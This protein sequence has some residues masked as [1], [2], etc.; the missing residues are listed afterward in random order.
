MATFEMKMKKKSCFFYYMMD[1]F[2]NYFDKGSQD[3]ILKN[4]HGNATEFN[5]YLVYLK[6][7]HSSL[8]CY[9][10]FLPI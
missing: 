5:F 7:I 9:I 8:L 2:F 10:T 4:L 1:L 6:P 3:A